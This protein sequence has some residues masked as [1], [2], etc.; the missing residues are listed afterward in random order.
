MDLSGSSSLRARTE[1]FSHQISCVSCVQP[2]PYYTTKQL[3][4]G[5]KWI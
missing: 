3:I 4:M 5:H 1:A 2:T